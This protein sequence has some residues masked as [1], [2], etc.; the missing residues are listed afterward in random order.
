MNLLQSL[1]INAAAINAVAQQE[2]ASVVIMRYNFI[3]QQDARPSTKG[4]ASS[5][6]YKYK[7]T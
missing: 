6:I 7:T 4:A 5:K 2:E 1:L 3:L